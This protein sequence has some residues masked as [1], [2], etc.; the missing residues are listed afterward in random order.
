MKIVKKTER[1]IL[2]KTASG[3]LVTKAIYP[4]TG[5]AI[6]LEGWEGTRLL[7]EV[8]EQDL[9]DFPAA[10]WRMDITPFLQQDSPFSSSTPC[11]IKPGCI[12]QLIYIES[13][14]DEG[15]ATVTQWREG[16]SLIDAPPA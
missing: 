9:A 3:C 8:D 2:F 15:V 1:S 7:L 6:D 12:D 10:R 5:F 13:N 11:W 16:Q 4:P 14:G